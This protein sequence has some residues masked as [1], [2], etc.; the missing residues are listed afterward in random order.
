MT[1]RR[2]RVGIALAVSVL[3]LAGQPA[4]A[5]NTLDLN[6]NLGNVMA[7]SLT[8]TSGPAG[9]TCTASGDWTGPKP[10]SGSETVP[11]IRATVT[12]GIGCTWPQVSTALVTW[13][14]ATTNMDGTPYNNAAGVRL[15]WTNQGNLSSFD[16]LQPGV[17]PPGTS[18]FFAMPTAT[19]FNVTGLG[20]GNWTFGAYSVATTGLCS[21][22]SNTASK[23]IT[24]AV[25]LTDSVT[26]TVP[27][28][29]TGVGVE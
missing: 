9:A 19:S 21:P 27:S 28:A 7:P 20:S 22:L 1:N 23:T 24:P 10:S 4:L 18:T 2:I 26:I 5:Q 8:W 25:T 11:P 6:V 17:L 29:I 13:I 12:Y 3:A 15:V 16:C 14:N